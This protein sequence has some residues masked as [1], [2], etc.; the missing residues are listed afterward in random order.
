MESAVL[1]WAAPGCG[2]LCTWLPGYA[3]RSSFWLAPQ[4]AAVL[5]Y[6]AQNNVEPFLEPVL[7]LCH[8]IVQRDA[9]VG[10]AGC[11]VLYA[12]GTLFMHSA[13][14]HNYACL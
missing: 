14:L 11:R 2:R 12:G 10:P 4:V 3:A 13:V 9:K 7:E 6:A 1:L 5:E 8:V